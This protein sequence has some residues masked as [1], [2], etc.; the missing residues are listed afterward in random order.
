M[1]KIAFEQKRPSFRNNKWQLEKK[2]Q[3]KD[4]FFNKINKLR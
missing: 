4:V 2:C 1:I 3:F